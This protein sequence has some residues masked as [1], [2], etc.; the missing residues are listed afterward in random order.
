MKHKKPRLCRPG[1]V[2]NPRDT[3]GHRCGLRLARTTN[4]SV[5]LGAAQ[6]ETLHWRSQD[7]WARLGY[8]AQHN[9]EDFAARVEHLL[10]PEGPMRQL[11]GGLFLVIGPYDDKPADP[12]R[13]Q[14][15]SAAQTATT[16]AFRR[17]CP[18]RA[19]RCSTIVS[20][21]CCCS[22]ARSSAWPA[23]LTGPKDRCGSVMGGTCCSP[24][25]PTTASCAGATARAR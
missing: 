11:Q 25:S 14:T 12:N 9:A 4:P 24:T 7:A 1:V 19:L 20:W 5:F 6:R 23:A 8:V 21:R 10:Q 16:S 2:A 17:A 18:T 15:P 22:R 3:F 13:K